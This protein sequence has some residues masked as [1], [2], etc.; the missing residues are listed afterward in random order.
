MNTIDQRI[1]AA[2]SEEDKA[3]LDQYRDNQNVLSEVLLS[4]HGI[5]GYFVILVWIIML[6]WTGLFGLCAVKFISADSVDSK[7]TWL[8]GGLVCLVTLIACKLWYYMELN[9]NTVMRELKRL[10]LQIGLLA[11]K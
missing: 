10:E 7:I 3:L 5:R 2:L 4:F 6:V 11:E 9:R 8:G 1:Q